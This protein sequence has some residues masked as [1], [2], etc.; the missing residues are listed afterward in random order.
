MKLEH[1]L[2]YKVFL[3]VFTTFALVWATGC[4]KDVTQ[5]AMESDAN[6]YVCRQNHKFYTDR[7]LFADKCP[8]CGT[9]E[10]F[11]VYGYVCEIKPSNPQH[12]PGCGQVTLASRGG[13]KGGAIQCGKCKRPVAAIKLPS[14]KELAAWSATKA[15]RDQVSVPK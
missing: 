15:T 9:I 11:E 1:L 3:S 4:R 6:G 14:A 13:G 12:A 10:L 2:A 7:S 8:Q 5:A